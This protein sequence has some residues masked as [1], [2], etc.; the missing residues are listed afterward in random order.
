M[1]H[2]LDQVPGARQTDHALATHTTFIQFVPLLLST[3]NAATLPW[4]LPMQC[5]PGYA[6]SMP[7]HWTYNLQQDIRR[8]LVV[9]N[10][11]PEGAAFCLHISHLYIKP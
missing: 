1:W 2:E 7:K 6:R 8:S 11:V 4:V 9:D 3:S 5:P 10:D